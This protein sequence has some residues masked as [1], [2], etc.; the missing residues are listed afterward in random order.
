MYGI[1]KRI[2]NRGVMLRNRR[3]HL[4]NIL[5][6]DADEF[7]EAPARINA[8]DFHISAQMRL[9]DAARPAHTIRDMHLRADEISRRHARHLR[10][11]LLNHPA[12]FMPKCQRR[13]KP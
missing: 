13:A 2:E 3:V 12:K 11:N 7:S 5:R 10:A 8:D 4:P 9:A 6:R 1:P